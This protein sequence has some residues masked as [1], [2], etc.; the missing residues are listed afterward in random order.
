MVSR[1]EEKGASRKTGHDSNRNFYAYPDNAGRSHT[2]PDPGSDSNDTITTSTNSI[3]DS[4]D[5]DTSTAGR[6]HD[7][8]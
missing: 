2:C 8:R 5:D 1:P 6:Q 3:S 7:Q 4:N